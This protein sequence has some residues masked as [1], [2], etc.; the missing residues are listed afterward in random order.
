MNGV[1]GMNGILDERDHS[2]NIWPFIIISA[3]LH[4]WLLLA[5]EHFSNISD[6]LQYSE[7]QNRPIT[8]NLKKVEKIEPENLLVPDRPTL[9]EENPN[10]NEEIVENPDIL[11]TK[12]SS[13][14]EGGGES[15]SKD[16][17]QSV[18][19]AT[20]QNYSTLG[21]EGFS[22][23][24]LGKNLAKGKE[25]VADLEKKII[26]NVPPPSPRNGMGASF[27]LSSYEW[28]W[29]P[30]VLDLKK[31][32]GQKISPPPVYTHLGLVSGVTRVKFVI[33]RD[34]SLASYT[35]LSHRGHRVLEETTVEAVEAVFPFKA[36]P[37][38]FPDPKLVLIGNFLYPDLR[39]LYRR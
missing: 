33:N 26:E 35:V 22:S 32:F 19:K 38:D 13:A 2:S 39:K 23:A 6:Q 28:E 8:V 16:S 31:K 34:G 3:I 25:S 1:L 21:A 37:T 12:S 7:D 29:A 15:P 30:W 14:Q 20:D 17:P 5:L 18:E 11:S 9:I 36:L 24:L 10:A 27:S 4:F